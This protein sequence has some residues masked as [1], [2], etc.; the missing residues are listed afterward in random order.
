MQV[1]VNDTLVNYSDTGSG[2]ILLCVHGWMHDHTTYN[3]LAR[4]LGGTYRVVALDLPN[5]GNSQTNDGIQGIDEFAAFLEAFVNK[6]DI[7]NY[8]FVGHSMGCQI[9]M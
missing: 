7:K 4:E 5:F 1:V 6:L 2:P 9:G 8:T 3:Q